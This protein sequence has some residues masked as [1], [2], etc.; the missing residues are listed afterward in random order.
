MASP[1]PR[2]RYAEYAA[3]LLV[4]VLGLLGA[5][6]FSGVL[7]IEVI[8]ALG[9]IL[10]TFGVYTLAYLA[11]HQAGFAKRE[12]NYY[13]VWGYIPAAIG[14][15]LVLTPLMNLLFALSVALIGLALVALLI[16]RL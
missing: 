3:I 6:N 14:I 13:L 7:P 10:A 1:E 11:A 15:A 5:L 12:R 2:S 16:V 4:V 8:F 9:V